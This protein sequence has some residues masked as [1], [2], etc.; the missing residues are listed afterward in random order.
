MFLLRLRLQY[1]SLLLLLLTIPGSS[2]PRTSTLE[3]SETI[4]S[5]DKAMKKLMRK[6]HLPAFA[7]TIIE[8]DRTLFESVKGYVDLEKQ[9]AAT[10]NSIFKIYSVSKVFTALEIFRE[11]EEG[12]IDLEDPLTQHLPHFS[13]RSRFPE[14]DPVTVKTLLAHRSGLPRNDC[15]TCPPGEQDPYSLHKFD[16]CSAD[17]FLAYPVGK[18]Y[19][20]SNLGYNL[21]GRIVEENRETGFE[22]YMKKHL[23]TDLGM[24][25][26][27]FRASDLES[28]ARVARGYEYYKRTYYPLYQN[29]V[30]NVPSG[31]LYS[32]LEDLSVFLQAILKNQVFSQENTL[33]Q[34]CKDHF[35]TE[36]DP[37]T[38]G[39][40][41][42][43]TQL[44]GGELLI[45]HDGGPD[46]GVGALVAAVPDQN[47][48]IAM[49]AN[50]TSFG[51]NISVLFAKEIL[52]QLLEE[53][54]QLERKQTKSEE[55]IYLPEKAL[56]SFEGLYIAFGM[57]MKVQ[58]RK[59]LLK[60]KIGGMNLTLIPV[61][62]REFR[63]SHWM[64][65]IGLTKIIRPPVDFDKLR[66]LFPP[67]STHPPPFTIISLDDISYEIC[68]RYPVQDELSE[69]WDHLLG[70]YDLAWRL[71]DNQRGSLSGSSYSISMEKG[72]LRMSGPFG[73]ILPLDDN[74]F[75][76]MAMPF[77]GETM[78]Y[79]PETGIIV[80][81]NAIY[82]P[83]KGGN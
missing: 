8:G 80:H 25:N 9:V 14:G 70:D 67:D 73:P 58:A 64:D 52:Q 55:D 77:A 59:K 50:S 46:D 82:T 20:Y 12:L 23:L 54:G 13:I 72:V 53:K 18:R 6:H 63:V 26:S 45:W 34:M 43:T 48:A 49:I 22:E 60:A 66:V 74:Y 5:L 30:K 32:S 56:Q 75:R 37:E 21:L 42:K 27:A 1:I 71:P 47:L 28:G 35:S 10:R 15:L 78:E 38:M 41:W 76:L 83:R 61:Q 62:E 3:P 2:V 19:K 4:T 11:M 40:G 16:W 31:N 36:W 39:L 68:P 7:M 65:K 33:E 81:Q 51:G 17:C 69:R 29:D 24:N 44:E 57:P 79:D